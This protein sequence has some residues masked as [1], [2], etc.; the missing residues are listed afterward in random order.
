MGGCPCR[1][2]VN[3]FENWHGYAPISF[4]VSTSFPYVPPL[5]GVML[6]DRLDLTEYGPH[7]PEPP[8]VLAGLPPAERERRVGEILRAAMGVD[9]V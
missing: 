7:D 5:R 3:V 2:V 4:S 8:S 6:G 9:G 1:P